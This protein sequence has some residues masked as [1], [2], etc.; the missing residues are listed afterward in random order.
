MQFEFLNP[1]AFGDK[2]KE[3]IKSELMGK[4]ANGMAKNLAINSKMKEILTDLDGYAEAYENRKGG[5]DRNPMEVLM[6][7]TL[8]HVQCAL[9]S[10]DQLLKKAIDSKDND[11]IVAFSHRIGLLRSALMALQAID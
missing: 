5:E 8:A 2:E 7:D 6:I 1:D 11:A 3:A 4:I 10:H 9:M